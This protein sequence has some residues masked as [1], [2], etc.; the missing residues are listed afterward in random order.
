MIADGIRTRALLMKPTHADILA[1]LNRALG[2]TIDGEALPSILR[3][4][5]SSRPAAG[6]VDSGPMSEHQRA[7]TPIEWRTF[8]RTRAVRNDYWPP[9]PAQAVPRVFDRCD[10]GSTSDAD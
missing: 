7:G 6:R 2:V 3:D 9:F 1:I 5:P 10:R 4:A 8:A